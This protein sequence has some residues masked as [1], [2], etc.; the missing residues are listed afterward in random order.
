MAETIPNVTIYG[1]PADAGSATETPANTPLNLMPPTSRSGNVGSAS[2][3]QNK[4]KTKTYQ[5]PSDLLSNRGIYGDNYVVFYVNVPSDSRL[6]KEGK[7]TTTDQDTTS[8]RGAVASA[9]YTATNVKVAAGAAIAGLGA[10]FNIPGSGTGKVAMGAAFGGVAGTLANKETPKGTPL[11]Q[12][13]RILESITLYT[14][15]SLTTRYGMNYDVQDLLGMAAIANVGEDIAKFK[16]GNGTA[17]NAAGGL[18]S[19]LAAGIL[20]TPQVGGFMSAATGL[21]GNPKKEQVF[22]NVDFRTFSF[23]YTFAPRNAKESEEVQNI[24]KTFKLHMHP[25][26]KDANGYLFLYPSEFDIYFY[27]GNE[28][29]MNLPRVTSCVLQEMSVNYTPNNQYT[30]FGDGASTQIDVTL[31]FRELAILTKAEIE[32]G[33]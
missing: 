9:G 16:N 5:Y 7:V 32:D 26:Y 13:R 28:E 27:Q 10:A 8:L 24:I 21:A 15:N 17:M 19:A 11:R 12:Q 3:Y 1:E 31:I 18:G 29:N 14:P 25:E 20:Q 23:Q 6:I 4:Y 30:T 22:Q 33:F 2:T